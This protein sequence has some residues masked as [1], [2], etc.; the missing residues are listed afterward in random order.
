VR[1]G[2]AVRGAKTLVS[3]K[4]RLNPMGLFLEYYKLATCIVS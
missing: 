1:N 4:K 2:D 3:H